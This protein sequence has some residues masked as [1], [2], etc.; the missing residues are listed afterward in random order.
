ME[1]YR[2]FFNM[3]DDIADYI[4]HKHPKIFKFFRFLLRELVHVI[5]SLVCTLIIL[6]SFTDVFALTCETDLPVTGVS[7]Y[8]NSLL[9]MIPDDYH[10]KYVVFHTPYTNNTN[11][12]YLYWGPLYVD[13]ENGQIIITTKGLSA[14]YVRYMYDKNISDWTYLTGK[15]TLKL[16][17]NDVV[18]TNLDLPLGSKS[19]Q[20]EDHI[21]NNT[22]VTGL[23]VFLP[24]LLFANLWGAVKHDF[25]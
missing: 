22:I 9:T 20:Y 21:N 17:V 1:N 12:Y 24:I 6:Y 25:A 7:S 11:R 8:A 19:Y 10:G 14:N 3:G 2:L 18:C 23:M 16:T 4:Y 15:Q 13:D 5:F